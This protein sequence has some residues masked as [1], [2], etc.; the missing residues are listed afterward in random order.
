M[1][2]KGTTNILF[3]I[4]T[5][6]LTYVGYKALVFI[7][8]KVKVDR[9]NKK[10]YVFLEKITIDAK[11]GIID[12]EMVQYEK[13][14]YKNPPENLSL[15]EEKVDKEGHTLYKT[16]NVNGDNGTMALFKVGKTDYTLYDIF[17]SNDIYVYGLKLENLDRPKLLKKYNIN[18]SFD[19]I[20]YITNHHLKK[21]TIFSSSNNI[22]MNYFMKTF[23]YAT[24]PESQIHLIDG[25]HKGYIYI[26]NNSSHYEIHLLYKDSD[27][28]FS[29]INNNDN[30]YFKI[31]DIKE[32]ISNIKYIK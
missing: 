5:V 18:D 16:Y 2:K 6:A 30:Q 27:Y 10:E 11:E 25:A 8:Y 9:H 26:L 7:N 1:M 14:A 22:K 17:S 21:P 19:V 23:T 28:V 31:D 24:V 12:D 3:L 15:K 32:F 29:F 13:V 4:L 20:N